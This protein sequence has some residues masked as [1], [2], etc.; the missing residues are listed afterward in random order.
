MKRMIEETFIKCDFELKMAPVTCS[1]QLSH[2][3]PGHTSLALLSSL[4][5]TS[6]AVLLCYN[7]RLI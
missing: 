5:S 1:V 3:F 2:G 6:L 7:D 4:A